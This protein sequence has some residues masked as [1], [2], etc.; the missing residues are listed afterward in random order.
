MSTKPLFVAISDLHFNINNLDLA[1]QALEAAINKAK[2][3]NVSLVIAGDLHDTKDI[4]RG[5]VAN[6]LLE[7]LGNHWLKS[8]IIL[9]GN[10]DLINEKSNE[11]GLNYLKNLEGVYIINQTDIP[12]AWI[13]NTYFIAYQSNSVDL[14]KKFAQIPKGSTIVMHQGF[15]GAAMGDYIQDKSSIDP[16][17]VKDFIVISGHYHRHQTIGTVTYIGSPFTHTFGEANDGLKG[18]LIVNED[19]SFTRVAL[20]LR[21]HRIFEMTWANGEWVAPELTYYTTFDS[22]IWVKMRGP[23][24]ELAKIN[25]KDLGMKLFCHTNYK[26]DKIPTDSIKLTNKIDNLSN[27]E[28]LDRLIDLI[29][30][31]PEHKAELKK[32]WR[33]LE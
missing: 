30:D 5:K 14:T 20:L 33:E 18:F 32:T 31:T 28:I 17:L 26:L 27:F 7:I 15:L 9:A 21:S 11:H 24:S 10:H 29:S 1:S 2:E 16:E 8:V 19:G 22:S 23:Q 3:L 12:R 4:I 6:K 13:K 25:K